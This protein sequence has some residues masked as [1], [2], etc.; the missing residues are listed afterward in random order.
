MQTSPALR[1]GSPLPHTLR[2]GALGRLRNGIRA[3]PCDKAQRPALCANVGPDIDKSDGA[4]PFRQRVRRIR[5]HPV[6]YGAPPGI[7]GLL[8]HD[9]KH[10]GRSEYAEHLGKGGGHIRP[11]VDRLESGDEIEGR[12]GIGQ[13]GNIPL[14]HFAMPGGDGSG[15]LPEAGGDALS[16]KIDPAD[17]PLRRVS[18]IAPDSPRR[19]IL[20][21]ASRASGSGDTCDRPHFASEA[22]PQFIAHSMILPD[23]PP[24]FRAF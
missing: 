24:G 19:R 14:P 20:Y 7:P 8:V 12:I 21:R 18:E 5:P 3:F 22:C 23:R 10:A 2:P 6:H 4:Q 9:Q 1:D 13:P 15:V 11:E 16:G 17:R